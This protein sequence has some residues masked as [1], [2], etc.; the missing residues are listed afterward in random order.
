MN[1]GLVGLSELAKRKVKEGFDSDLGQKL[2]KFD[3]GH[4]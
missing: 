3:R 1:A 4:D 2:G